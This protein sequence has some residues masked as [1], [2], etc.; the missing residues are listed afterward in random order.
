MAAIVDSRPL[1]SGEGP[2]A[3]S[4]DAPPPLT[5]QHV[6]RALTDTAELIALL[7]SSDALEYEPGPDPKVEAQSQLSGGGGPICAIA[8]TFGL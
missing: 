1:A 6:E 2:W 5:R 8:G 7:E 3:S 4:N